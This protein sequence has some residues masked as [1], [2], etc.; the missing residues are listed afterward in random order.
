MRDGV[1]MP[2]A[3][4]DTAFR[5]CEAQHAEAISGKSKRNSPSPSPSPVKGEGILAE[6]AALR[7]KQR[8]LTISAW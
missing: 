8:K 3:R 7:E 2:S 1:A 4:N 6:I 5:H